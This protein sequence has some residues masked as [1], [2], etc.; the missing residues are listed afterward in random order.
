[1]LLLQY[2]NKVEIFL[3]YQVNKNYISAFLCENKSKPELQCDGKCY[4]KKQLKA[5][6]E[7]QSKFPVSIKEF[8]EIIFFC[9]SAE[10]NLI[11]C[12]TLSGRCFANFTPNYYHSPSFGIFQPPK[13]V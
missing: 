7:N 5:T 11:P 9:S 13:A 8:Q 10:I 1:M 3:C 12:N 6:D 4:M 2:F